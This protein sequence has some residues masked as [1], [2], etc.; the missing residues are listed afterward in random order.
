M[1]YFLTCT[2]ATIGKR[3][4][5]Q[6]AW[7]L[8]YDRGVMAVFDGV[9]GSWQ[10]QDA[11]NKA[12]MAIQELAISLPPINQRRFDEVGKLIC[13]T[14]HRVNHEL[15]VNNNGSQ[16]TASVMVFCEDLTEGLGAVIVNI[17]DSRIYAWRDN[18]TQQ[19]IQLT[20]DDSAFPDPRL[21]HVESRSEMT[22]SM[23]MAFRFRNVISKALGD[24][25]LG[26]LKPVVVFAEDLNGFILTTD[27]VHDNL[28][29]AKLFDTLL[30]AIQDTIE[31]FQISIAEQIVARAKKE[32]EDTKNLRHK[33][34]DI[35]AI[36]V[37]LKP[38]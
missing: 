24:S 11:S 31:S 29:H 9:G 14:L 28:S 3:E 17:G 7:L 37:C 23:E 36:V 8:D 35:T 5:N 1:K 12:R 33:N 15:I 34:D 2:G 16:T 13:E 22:N 4:P 27:G 25:T 18:G 26:E 19:L 20:H 30:S 38:E 10:G 32:S 6:D 21:D